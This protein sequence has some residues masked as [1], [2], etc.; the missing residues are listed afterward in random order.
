MWVDA[1]ISSPIQHR[2]FWEKCLYTYRV[3]NRCGDRGQLNWLVKRVLRIG[4][5]GCS[6]LGGG[7]HPWAVLVCC[8]WLF[9]GGA[10]R[11]VSGHIYV[12]ESKN[13]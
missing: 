2:A 5:G 6:T 11:G 3:L 8:H 13:L 9:S 10:D 4:V 12:G 7:H 1:E